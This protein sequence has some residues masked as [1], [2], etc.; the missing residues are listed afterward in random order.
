[1]FRN[2]LDLNQPEERFLNE[3]LTAYTRKGFRWDHILYC[4]RSDFPM[5]DDI[6]MAKAE[7]ALYKWFRP[8]S[9][10]ADGPSVLVN[11][12]CFFESDQ[13]DDPE[14]SWNRKQF[15]RR[16]GEHVNGAIQF[17]NLRYMKEAVHEKYNL[18]ASLAQ[19]EEPWLI[20]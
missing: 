17:T 14:N 7:L 12:I 15:L 6:Y 5:M 8:D 13:K 16:K 18:Y 10:S 4:L 1:M 9:E 2:I 20:K 19:G 3:A 11:R